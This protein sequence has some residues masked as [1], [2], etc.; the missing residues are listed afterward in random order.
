M[1]KSRM[2][3]DCEDDAMIILLKEGGNQAKVLRSNGLT[4]LDLIGSLLSLHAVFI[5]FH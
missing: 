3:L 2:A 4:T 1:K 5:L